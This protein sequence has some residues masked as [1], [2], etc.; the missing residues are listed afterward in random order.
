MSLAWWDF[1]MK[2][3]AHLIEYGLLFF[4]IQRAHNWGKPFEVRDYRLTFVWVILYALSDE[5]HQSFTPGRKPNIVDVG[6]DT[7][8]GFLVYLKLKRFV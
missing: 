7:L 8:G 3:I 6:Y 4:S 1:L 5:Y 2:K